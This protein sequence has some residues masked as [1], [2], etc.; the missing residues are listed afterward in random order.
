M[1]LENTV[2]NQA[3]SWPGSGVFQYSAMVGFLINPMFMITATK[4]WN[5]STGMWLLMSE[6]SRHTCKQLEI[7]FV[8]GYM[9]LIAV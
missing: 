2:R 4:V 9:Y 6:C 7:V 1:F 5:M 3:V 8:K